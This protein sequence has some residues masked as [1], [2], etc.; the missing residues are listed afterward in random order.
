MT[1][2][3]ASAAPESTTERTIILQWANQILAGDLGS[4][5]TEYE[6][7][8]HLAILIPKAEALET[9]DAHLAPLMEALAWALPYAKEHA[10]QGAQCCGAAE[11]SE[12][13]GICA[14]CHEHT[15][16]DNPD[17][18]HAQAALKA[19]DEATS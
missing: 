11:Y 17:L 2:A 15:G 5:Y 19:A 4:N 6:F 13:E 16:F 10:E 8:A 9:R 18:E 14:Q 3:T 7:A 12:A 1:E